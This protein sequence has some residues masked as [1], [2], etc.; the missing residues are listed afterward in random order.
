MTAE[1]GILLTI[2]I[3]DCLPV[4]LVDPQRRVVAAVHAGWRGALARVIEKA[5]GDMR[6]AFGSDPQELIAARGA[7]DSRLLLR[8]GRG[9]CGSLPRELCG[10]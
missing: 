1:P 9:S 8:S 6:R 7:I 4:L 3:A 2:R 10:C 5:V